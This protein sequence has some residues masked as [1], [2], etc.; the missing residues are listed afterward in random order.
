MEILDNT[1]GKIVRELFRYIIK[2]VRYMTDQYVDQV[3]HKDKMELVGEMVNTIIH[4]FKSPFNSIQLS[5]SMLKEMY[6][7][8]ETQ[9]WCDLIQAQI[10]RMLGMAEEVLELHGD[11]LY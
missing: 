2:R 7:D 1:K 4:D 3:V 8:E 5:S 10:T 6:P 11:A 9:E